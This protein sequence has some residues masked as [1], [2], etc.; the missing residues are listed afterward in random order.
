M[1]AKLHFWTKNFEFLPS[2]SLIYTFDNFN[3]EET[4]V[5]ILFANN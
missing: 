3:I 5:K 1:L 4:R 2:K